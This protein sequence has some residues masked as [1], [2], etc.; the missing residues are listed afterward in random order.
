VSLGHVALDGSKIRANASKHKAMSYRRMQT[1]EP[2]LAAEVARWL[3]AA[4]DAC[5]DKAYG[6]DRRGDELPEWVTNKQHRLEKIRAAKAALEADAQDDAETKKRKEDSSVAG[7]R[8]GRPATHPPGT[9][10]DRAQRNFTDPDSRIMKTRDGFIQ[11]YNAQA[12]VDADHQVIVAQGL[13][14]QASD[15]HQLDPLL[16]HIR[17]NTGR[18]ARELSADAGYC[19]EE[20]LTALTRRHVRGYIATGRQRHGETSATG[21]RKTVP[22][23]RVHAMKLR[24]RRAG[25]RSRYRLRKQV[26]EPVFSQIKQG[27]GFLQFL[28]RGLS[29]VA[30]EWRFVCSAHNVLKLAGARG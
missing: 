11:G 4:S 9:P 26:V 22:K 19:S 27:R 3:A 12:A 1:A 7:P 29:Q 5:E 18:Q 28:L 16:A 30:G 14:N 6:I 13:T 15:A 23:T 24:L 21:A 2:E 8:R 25:H 20:N 10:R 17:C